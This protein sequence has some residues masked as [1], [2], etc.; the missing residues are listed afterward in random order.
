M[1]NLSSEVQ[2]FTEVEMTTL[3]TLIAETEVG[4]S[5]SLSLSLSLSPS[6]SLSLLSLSLS[7]SLFLSPS[8]PP[9]LS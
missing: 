8:S 1:K 6:L 3:E 7:L 5:L 4:G 2:I 9:L